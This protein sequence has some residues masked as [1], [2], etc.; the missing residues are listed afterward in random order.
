MSKKIKSKL[1]DMDLS[2]RLAYLKNDPILPDL[3]KDK[4]LQECLQE[5]PLNKITID[6]QMSEKLKE[7][8]F[9]IYK[10]YIKLKSYKSSNDKHTKQFYDYF[11]DYESKHNF[12]CGPD[13]IDNMVLL[14]LSKILMMQNTKY[15][16]PEYK[17]LYNIFIKLKNDC[18]NI[19]IGRKIKCFICSTLS[20][21]TD[22]M[23]IGCK[24]PQ[25]GGNITHKYMKLKNL[26]YL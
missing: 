20:L 11:S 13:N 21:S 10:L 16:T 4:N 7:N 5:L 14:Q 18:E 24:A 25:T 3:I 22:G 17:E 1:E 23:C 19:G 2:I 26:K 9:L 6:D 15:D 12:N 8:L